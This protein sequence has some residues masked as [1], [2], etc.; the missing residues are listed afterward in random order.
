MSNDNIESAAND[1]AKEIQSVIREAYSPDEQVYVVA[2]VILDDFSDLQLFANTEDYYADSEETAVDR[3][4]F[5]QFESEGMG[6]DFDSLTDELGEVE[7]SDEEPENGNAVDWLLAM[8]RAMQIAK[9]EGAFQFGG[10]EAIIYCS[11]VD[12]LNAI[13]IEDL[14]AKFLNNPHQYEEASKGLK[15]VAEEW[16]GA[17]EEENFPEF[18]KAFESRLFD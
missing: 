5:P 6:L 13:W 15:A 12:S 8:T 11:M 17:D 4:Y 9:K 7:D 3:W 10:N 2:L 14:T 18:R 16:F 1:L